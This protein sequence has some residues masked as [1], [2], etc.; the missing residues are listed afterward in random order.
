MDNILKAYLGWATG[1]GDYIDAKYTCRLYGRSNRSTSPGFGSRAF[2]HFLQGNNNS[3]TTIPPVPYDND[4]NCAGKSSS[5]VGSDPAA[6][7]WKMTR[8][9]PALL[10]LVWDRRWTDTDSDTAQPNG[11]S[12]FG[13]PAHH[14]TYNVLFADYHVAPH[15]WIY[16]A[17]KANTPNTSLMNIPREFRTDWPASTP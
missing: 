13:M 1:A 7:K 11:A 3:N 9:P 4:S 10:G 17:G 2:V 12:Y 8:W 6:A 14:P 5:L 15:H 16:L